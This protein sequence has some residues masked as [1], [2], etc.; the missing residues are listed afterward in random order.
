MKRQRRRTVFIIM[1]MVAFAIFTLAGSPVK[2]ENKPLIAILP[3][4]EGDLN[5][6]GM[7]PE[8]ILAGI[9]R[10]VTDKLSE[11]EDVEVVELSEVYHVL[12]QQR[13]GQDAP[14]DPEAAAEIGRILGVDSIIMGTLSQLIVT[15]VGGVSYGPITLAGVK[16]E[17]LLTTRVVNINTGEVMNS[18]QGQGEVMQASLRISD[19]EGLVF[20]SDAFAESVLGKSIQ[21]AV[22]ELA[23]NITED[24]DELISK[25]VAVRGQV[26][27]VVGDNIVIDVGLRQNLR[28]GQ[29]GKLLKA[30]RVKGVNTNVT[31]PVGRV[32]IIALNEDF[33]VVNLLEGEA[34]AEEGDFVEFITG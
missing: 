34:T 9:T 24:P 7:N 11:S 20:G 15:D 6:N 1:V 31:I 27:M 33:A 18:F 25:R 21:K 23:A 19:I 16:A 26:S 28:V 3:F 29:E 17:V 8:E 4:V 10:M 32:K 14:V 2:A 12:Y 30:V 13:A 5:W 22:D